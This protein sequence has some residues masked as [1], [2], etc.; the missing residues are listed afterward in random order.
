[1]IK[2]LDKLISPKK[3]ERIINSEVIQKEFE[4]E[5]HEL[6]N[7]ISINV[8][9]DSEIE[10]LYEEVKNFNLD[11]LDLKEKIEKLKSLGLVNTPSVK[12]KEK[13]LQEAIEEKQNL[14][15][16]KKKEI[17][18]LKSEKEMIKHYNLKYSSYKY[19]PKRE[20]LNILE[21]YNLVMGE[22]FMYAKE[23]P[24]RA[25]NIISNFKQE[26]EDSEVVVKIVPDYS[27]SNYENKL[28][29]ESVKHIKEL[30][31]FVANHNGYLDREGDR[32]EMLNMYDRQLNNYEFKIKIRD[33]LK[34]KI[35]NQLGC[36]RLVYNLAL[37]TK[38]E[39]F[40]K[41]VRLSKFD[42]IKQLPELKK[43]FKWLSNVHS[44]TLQGTIERLEKGYD[45]FFSDLKRGITTS[46]P[47]FSKKK[48]WSS[49]E[50]K[51]SAVKYTGNS[52]MSIS[53]IG[54]IKFFKSREIEGE[55]KIVRIVKKADGYYLNIV[56]DK[57]FDKCDNQATVISIQVKVLIK[58]RC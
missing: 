55:I 47:K 30:R 6:M 5:L 45:K 13:E 46:K 49:V 34:N 3:E 38:E 41:G 9:S 19:I 14:I 31:D 21:K 25:V 1:M 39:S 17:E 57:D 37:E 54:R 53:K 48:K 16:E 2:F 11:N 4:A 18:F 42:L 7:K 32:S 33:A 27:A 43:E 40:K 26:I 36:T 35:E 24:D 20:F 22:A 58:K 15:S 23:I 12:I 28:K 50:Y 51:S 29:I 52:E 44:Q 8:E 10:S 56:T